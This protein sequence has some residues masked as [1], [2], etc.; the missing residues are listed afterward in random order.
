MIKLT[1]SGLMNLLQAAHQGTN[2]NK[3]VNY[4]EQYPGIFTGMK[5]S[6]AD[7][8]AGPNDDTLAKEQ[9]TVK[10]RPSQGPTAPPTEEMTELDDSEIMTRYFQPIYK[11]IYNAT[12]GIL[13]NAVIKTIVDY[14]KANDIQPTYQ[15]IIPTYA[16]LVKEKLGNAPAINPNVA[17][18]IM[19]NNLV[20]PHLDIVS[21][22]DI[23]QL[24]SRE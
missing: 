9:G 13:D 12:A 21:D 7:D 18:A 20:V 16:Y 2:I 14:C 10:L 22:Q 15:S 11:Q 23:D 8:M 17:R 6:L 24:L 3:L 5:I 19:E 4:A 1:A